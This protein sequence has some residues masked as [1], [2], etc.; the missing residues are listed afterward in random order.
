MAFDLDQD[1]NDD[2]FVVNEG[3]N[4]ELLHNND[5]VLTRVTWITAVNSTLTGSGAVVFDLEGDG[6]DDMPRRRCARKW[7]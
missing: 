2:I 3:Q 4:N 7:R 6:D 5:G 1:G